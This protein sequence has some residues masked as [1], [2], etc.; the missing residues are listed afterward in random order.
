LYDFNDLRVGDTLSKRKLWGQY[1]PNPDQTIAAID[2]VNLGNVWR[3]R[4][5]VSNAGVG[6]MYL[7]EG[8]GSNRGL[9]PS[10]YE[11]ESGVSTECV[12]VGGT[13]IWGTGACDVRNSNAEVSKRQI[14]ISPNPVSDVL[15][16]NGLDVSLSKDVVLSNAFGQV[17]KVVKLTDNGQQISTADFPNGLYFCQIQDANHRVLTLKFVVAH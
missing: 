6:Q 5:R 10:Y 16:I 1:K 13:T 7:V 15:I 3:K 17:L 2:S 11:F 9:I 4:Y 8:V 12:R 14:A